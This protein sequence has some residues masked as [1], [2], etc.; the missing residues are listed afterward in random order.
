MFKALAAIAAVTVCCLG[1]DYPAKAC[2]GCSQDQ[3]N[4][5]NHRKMQYM[6]QE[7]EHQNY[8]QQHQ[9]KQMER[10]YMSQW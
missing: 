7:M 8:L 2:I 9:L 6:Q 5:E 10:R 3:I 4:I 1:N